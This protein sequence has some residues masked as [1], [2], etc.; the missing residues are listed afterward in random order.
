MQLK[1][2]LVLLVISKLNSVMLVLRDLDPAGHGLLHKK[3]NW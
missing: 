1:Q 3:V 2:H